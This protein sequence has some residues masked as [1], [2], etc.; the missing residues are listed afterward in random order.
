MMRRGSLWFTSS[1]AAAIAAAKV[2]WLVIVAPVAVRLL[3]HTRLLALIVLQPGGLVLHLD[4][5]HA[6]TAPATS[7]ALI[8]FVGIPV[9]LRGGM[10]LLLLL[11]RL[12]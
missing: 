5:H 7:D 6:A 9:W 10:M 3:P 12:L 4:N 1:A 11:R 2:R 8:T